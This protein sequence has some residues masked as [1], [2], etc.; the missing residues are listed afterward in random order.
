[1]QLKSRL[2]FDKK[3]IGKKLY[4][5]FRVHDGERDSWFMYDHDELLAK[6]IEEGQIEGTKTWELEKPYH[7]PFLST[8]MKELLETYRI[9][10]TVAVLA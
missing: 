1:V 3:Y 8:R 4:I 6:L 10:D 5:S 7:F 9:P 2:T